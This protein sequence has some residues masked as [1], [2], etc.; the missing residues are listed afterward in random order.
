MFGLNFEAFSF[1]F[2]CIIQK[3]SQPKVK[4]QTLQVYKILYLDF[5]CQLLPRMSEAKMS[6]RHL[7]FLANL[8]HRMMKK[9]R[10]AS[11]RSKK[12]GSYMEYTLI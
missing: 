4:G 10:S 11:F 9:L 6:K 1:V 5:L 3:Q 2:M 12:Y 8:E 7:Y